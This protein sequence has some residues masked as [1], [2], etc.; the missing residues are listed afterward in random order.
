MEE[1]MRYSVPLLLLAL[2][3]RPGISGAGDISIINAGFEED[4][5]RDGIPD[6]WVLKNRNTGKVPDEGLK[7]W[8][9]DREVSHSGGASIRAG[10]TDTTDVGVW[11]QDG[12]R[13]PEGT[14]YLRLS[15][16]IKTKDLRSSGGY[17][18]ISFGDAN[19]QAIGTDVNM[20]SL[21]S[22]RDW[23][24]LTGSAA[25]PEHAVTATLKCGMRFAFTKCGNIWFD[26]LRLT[27]A[28]E[29]FVVKTLYM[30]ENP[31]PE[32]TPAEKRRGFI[33]FDRNYLRVLMNN[34][35]PSESERISSLSVRAS[36][37]EYEP[38]TLTL[39]ALRPLSDLTLN[40]SDLRG[41][42]GVIKAEYIDIRA[43]RYMPKRGEGRWGL[44]QETLMDEVPLMLEKA[45]F[46]RVEQNKN[47]TFWLTVHV[48][49][50]QPPGTYRGTVTIKIP[51]SAG[52]RIPLLLEVYPFD[53]LTPPKGITFAMYVRGRDNPEWIDETFSDMKA[54]G[55][56]T[57]AYIG[58]GP[59]MEI[60]DGN[61]HID[62][63]GRS[64]L[65]QNMAAHSRAGFT[66]PVLWL[67]GGDIPALC[68]KI[69]PIESEAFARAYRD[70]ITQIVRHGRENGWPEIIFQSI[71]EPFEW[72]Q[73]LSVMLRLGQLLRSVPGVRIENDGMNGKWENF[74]EEAYQ[75][76]DVINLHDGP[77]L[78]RHESYD[79]GAWWKFYSRAVND[80]KLIWF[81]N[82]DITAWHPEPVRFMSGFGLYKS[83]AHGFFPQAYM[84]TV[85]PE[86]PAAAYTSPA[87]RLSWRLA[88]FPATGNRS[89]GPTIAYEAFR[90]GI[91]D[92]RYLVTLKHTLDMAYRSGNPEIIAR[93]NAVFEPVLSKIESA[94]FNGCTG[95]AMQGNWTGKCEIL[96]DGRRFIRGD[97]KTDNNWRFDDY[98]TLRHQIA[99][100][101]VQ[102]Q[103]MM[104]K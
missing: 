74:S 89:G 24:P 78:D 83:G 46:Y 92:Y 16:W 54:H 48:P 84:L 9:L 101:I 64:A 57:I 67:M 15:I 77:V 71:D 17:A 44:F 3:A 39:H 42:G 82:I 5:N 90:E 68:E 38:A 51:E 47:Q 99:D 95:L 55:L 61:I 86:D 65:E 29:S 62:W 18:N 75:L 93:A 59:D 66:E 96:P 8:I 7:S 60:S 52:L 45:D 40:I 85:N 94:T 12:I 13:I 98:D 34:A 97:H 23:T 87:S 11:E 103:R 43:V 41:D 88:R 25:V 22:S 63:N 1:S 80:G 104:S 56:N 73:R 79:T 21:S 6:G 20:V 72:E 69:G 53:L 19:G 36:R 50:T 91:D 49:G 30:D 26:D 58:R 31:L 32:L 102:L 10:V 70:V 33:L 76:T 4:S 37:G 14:K 28:S 27:T 81:Y 2:F 35:I 100:G